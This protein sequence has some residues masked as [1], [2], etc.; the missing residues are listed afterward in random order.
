METFI[1]HYPQTLW[2]Y[3]TQ[4]GFSMLPTALEKLLK[5]ISHLSITGVFI[6]AGTTLDI[7][8]FG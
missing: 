7:S 2:S 6:T 3:I 8:S 5:A 4:L 1:C